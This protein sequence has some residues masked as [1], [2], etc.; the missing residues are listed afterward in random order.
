MSRSWA[1]WSIPVLFAALCCLVGVASAQWVPLGPDGGDVRSLSYDPHN[2]DRIFLGTSAGQLFVSND[3]GASWSRFAHLG[4]GNDYVL[5]N[6]EI[7]P[8]S[9]TMYVAAWSVERE[10]GDL[11]RS[12]DGGRSWQ[13]LPGMHGKSIRALALAPSD[14]KVLV[15]GALDGVFRSR[16]GGNSWEQISPPNHAEIK[17]IDSIAIDP[18]DPNVVYA[19]TWHLAWKTNDG[20]RNW[21]PI[22]QGVID[23]SDVF[24]IIVD[25]SNPQ[26]VYLSACSG[27]YKS[28]NAAELFHKVQGIPFSARRTRV[29]KQDPLN[30]AVVYAGTTEGLWKTVDAGKTWRR[31]TAANIIVNDV[32]VDPRNA[33]HVLIATDRSGVLASRDAGQTFVA[34]NR[35]FAHRQVSSVVVDRSDPEVLYAGLVNDKEFG[36]VFVS[37]N[38][39]QT[40][41]QVNDGIRKLDIFTLRQAQ[42][43]ALLAGT[44]QGIYML[45]RGGNG[46][47]PINLVLREKII[48]APKPARLAK[49]KKT[50]QSPAAPRVEWIKSELDAR[51]VNLQLAAKKWFAASSAGLFTSL[52][53]G[54]SWRGGPVLGYRDF[55]T[56]DVS[57]RLVIATT[58]KVVLI[59]NDEGETW[60]QAQIPYFITAIRGA[61]IG[62]SDSLWLA[63]HEGAFRSL[64]R[65]VT[66][67]HVLA[68]LPS[69]HVS[70]ITY[71]REGGRL[72]AV[73][74]IGHLYASTDAGQSWQRQ[75]SGFTV[76]SLTVAHGRLLAVTAFDGV[77]MQVSPKTQRSAAAG[78]GGSALTN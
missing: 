65:G 67:E 29:L 59:S 38:G 24:S 18:R 22:K 26:N 46:W 53:G 19:G 5:D 63:T 55:T 75:D 7:E 61:A 17:N 13:T 74:G 34:S 23:D 73:S 32:H 20:G 40:W 30:P 14:P 51:V 2:P 78:A 6:T 54:K 56:V 12:T 35:G 42:N 44:N 57:G 47:Q 64:D 37:R 1:K 72:L 50:A 41:Q 68:G 11:F 21:H 52:D 49:G 71:D 9:G 43:D 66:W 36:G 33:T 16:D 10:S 8:A 3:K 48:P 4:E 45:P 69:R 27:I 58:P 15:T 39:G 62:P 25:Y 28:E 60:V 70:S 76:R 31:I 77:I